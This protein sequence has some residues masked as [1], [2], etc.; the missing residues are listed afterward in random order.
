MEQLPQDRLTYSCDKQLLQALLPPFY[1]IFILS[2][3]LKKDL[4]LSRSSSREDVDCASFKL[5]PALKKHGLSESA[6]NR[7]VGYGCL[8]AALG[9]VETSGSRL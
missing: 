9:W 2:A 8:I 3:S 4:V 7:K 6:E 5:S 1:R